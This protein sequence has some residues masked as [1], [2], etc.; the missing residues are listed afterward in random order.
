MNIS[1]FAPPENKV[2]SRYRLDDLPLPFCIE[3][4]KKDDDISVLS[5]LPEHFPR[6]FDRVSHQEFTFRRMGNSLFLHWR[7]KTEQ[8]D[9]DFPD[10]LDSIG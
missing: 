10:L 5:K 2:N 1:S 8:G 3:I 7:S 4:R 6:R 9:P